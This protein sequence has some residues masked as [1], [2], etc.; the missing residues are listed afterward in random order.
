MLFQS[1]GSGPVTRDEMPVLKMAER[2]KLRKME[3]GDR[4]ITASDLTNMDV[5]TTSF[6][7]LAL[8]YGLFMYRPNY[9]I[10]IYYISPQNMS[11]YY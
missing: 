2:V 7:S 8:K 1:Q 11:I 4:H 3:T 6:I 10:K 5:S 9:L